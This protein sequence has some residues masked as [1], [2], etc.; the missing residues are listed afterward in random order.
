MCACACAYVCVY[1]CMRVRECAYV[2][3]VV[4][5][6]CKYVRV[7][8]CASVFMYVCVDVNVQIK[9]SCLD[10]AF[11]KAQLFAYAVCWCSHWTLEH[12]TD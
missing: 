2:S 7:Y 4:W 3:V 12:R 1:V 10:T 5:C 9:P 11:W 8:M 6:D